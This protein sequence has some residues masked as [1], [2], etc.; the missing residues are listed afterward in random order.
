MAV[1]C[2]LSGSDDRLLLLLLLLL[3]S[4]LH[5][6]DVMGEAAVLLMLLRSLPLLLLDQS[7]PQMMSESSSLV[8]RCFSSGHAAASMLPEAPVEIPVKSTLVYSLIWLLCMFSISLQSCIGCGVEVLWQFTVHGTGLGSAAA[9][10]AAM[11][12]TDGEED[13]VGMRRRG[14]AA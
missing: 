12:L 11:V 9:L 8:L 6:E 5:G 3:G 7:P 4:L 10:T 2:Q 13:S 1:P 14:R